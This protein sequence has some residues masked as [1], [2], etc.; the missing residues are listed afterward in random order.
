MALCLIQTL[1]NMCMALIGRYIVRYR[2]PSNA[3]FEGGKLDE[4]LAI[5]QSFP[6][7]PLSLNVSPLEPMINSSKFYL[8][9]FCE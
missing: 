6:C 7:K 8:S 2:V 5:C 4:W 9:K 3:K 1:I